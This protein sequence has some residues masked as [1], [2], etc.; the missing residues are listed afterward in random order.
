M[1]ICIIYSSPKLGDV[2]L[3]LPIINSISKYHRSKVQVCINESI[4]LGNVFSDSNYISEIFYNSFRRGKYFIKDVLDLRKKLL[5]RKIT[6]VYLLEKTKGSILSAKLSKV[7]KIYSYGLGLQKFFSSNKSFIS[8][9]DLKYNYTVQGKKFLKKINIKYEYDDELIKI[10]EINLIELKN[11]FK[12]KKK[13][14]VILAVDA[15]ELNRIWPME[16]FSKLINLLHG[17]SLA[18]TFFVIHY[19][20]HQPYFENIKKNV[21]L[22][23][24]LVDCKKLKKSE[25][26]KLI[27]LSDY[28]IGIDSGPS[29]I[30]GALNKKTFTIFGATDA[31]L[32]IFNS[33]IKI[34]SDI[35]DQ[36]REIGIKRCG[37]NFAKDNFEVKTINVQ[38]VFEIIK[39]NLENLHK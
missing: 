23:D 29:C 17:S 1:S 3:Q 34:K 19:Q 12:N 7:K 2:A 6:I 15:T 10:S 13:P 27:S 35:Y 37:D 14:W 9:N 25:I 26:I 21:N 22:K 28:F 31:S 30:S 33:V 20:D 38:K 8:K 4:D 5:E 18:G 16:N 24:N 11:I 36:S 32:P 39:N